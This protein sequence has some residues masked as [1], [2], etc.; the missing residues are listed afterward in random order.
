MA[1]STDGSCATRGGPDVRGGHQMCVDTEGNHIYLHGGWSGSK[2]LS[3]FWKFDVKQSQWTC[4]SSDASQVVRSCCQVEP[5]IILLSCVFSYSSQGGPG[6][7]SCH[8]LCYD[9][10]QRALYLLGRYV[11]SLSMFE[12]QHPQVR[13][14]WPM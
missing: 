14:G 9:A 6:A 4:L 11:D 13:T 3:D 1:L 8:C 10:Q 12:Q 5:V 7:R 2:E